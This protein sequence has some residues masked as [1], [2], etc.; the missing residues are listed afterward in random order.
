ME[1]WDIWDCRGQKT[2]KC[3]QPGEALPAGYYTL[4]VHILLYHPDGRIL[5]QKRSMSKQFYPGAWDI[6][7]GRVMAGEE[8]IAAAIREVREELGI[9]L[10]PDGLVWL[11]RLRHQ[12][13]FCDIWAAEISL[14]TDQMILQSA[15][16]DAVRFADAN[17][18]IQT[19]GYNKEPAYIAVLREFAEKMKNDSH[20]S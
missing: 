10:F 20:H 1:C 8:S 2:G 18:A 13:C 11:A 14:S 12:R 6:T 7:G 9:A 5:L 19:I 4:L 16:V 3:L 15:E 17:E